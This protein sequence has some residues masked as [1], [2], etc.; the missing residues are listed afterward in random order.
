M[1]GYFNSN[2]LSLVSMLEKNMTINF[3]EVVDEISPSKKYLA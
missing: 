1:S 3:T 2:L